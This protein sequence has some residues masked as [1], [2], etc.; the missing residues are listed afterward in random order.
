MREKDREDRAD[1]QKVLNLE[2]VNVRVV[3]GLVI[4]QHEVDNVA[5]GADEEELEGGE[6]KR[7]EE[8]PEQI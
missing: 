2:G 5:G 6:V 3:G 1:S 8:S 7:I 4:V